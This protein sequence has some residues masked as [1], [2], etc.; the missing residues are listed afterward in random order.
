MKLISNGNVPRNSLESL[1]SYFSE[2]KCFSLCCYLLYCQ[3]DIK[4]VFIFGLFKQ[5][6]QMKWFCHYLLPLML[7]QMCLLLYFLWNAKRHFKRIFFFFTR[8]V[9]CDHE[10]LNSEVTKTQQSKTIF[11]LFVFLIFWSLTYSTRSIWTLVF[12]NILQFLLKEKHTS[13][14]NITRASK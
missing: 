9:C 1:L 7:F 2:Y 3:A 6:V 13:P 12:V 5:I 11:C 10:M 14:F 8:T 4:H